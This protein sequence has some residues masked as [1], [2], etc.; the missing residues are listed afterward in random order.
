MNTM[1]QHI[2]VLIFCFFYLT[3]GDKDIWMAFIVF[4]SILGIGF[5][6]RNNNQTERTK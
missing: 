6:L 4:N 2:I 3:W 1:Y 5:S